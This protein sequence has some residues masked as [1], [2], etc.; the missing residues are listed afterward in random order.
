[1]HYHDSGDLKRMGEYKQLAP[2][3]FSAFVEF[4]KIVSRK[5][6]TI[7]WKYRELI[8]IAVPCTT[9]MPLLPRC[10]Y[11]RRSARRSYP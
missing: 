1:M 7:P 9:P 3:E 6:G 11:P 2:T 5:D 10:A 4:D 8:A